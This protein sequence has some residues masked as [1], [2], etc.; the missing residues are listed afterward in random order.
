MKLALKKPN[1]PKKPT[2]PDMF[3]TDY[4]TNVLEEFSV[5][6]GSSFVIDESKIPEGT[7][8]SEINFTVECPYDDFF[9]T[10]YTQK[11]VTVDNP[12][13]QK[14]LTKYEL[15]LKVWEIKNEKYK[16]DYKKYKE[17]MAILKDKDLQDALKNAEML[18]VKHGKTVT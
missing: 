12:N 18:L 16:K 14:L 1:A 7:K 13:Y 4:V 9:V 15:D 3:Y 5:E 11:K 6:P 2:L 10:M 17:D 8:L